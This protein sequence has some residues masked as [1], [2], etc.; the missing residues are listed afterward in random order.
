[1]DAIA[2]VEPKALGYI[3]LAEAV[4]I[5]WSV[6]G[7]KPTEELYGKEIVELAREIY[8]TRAREAKA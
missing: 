2:Y 1:M 6:E 7:V 4:L 8:A 3:A 5:R